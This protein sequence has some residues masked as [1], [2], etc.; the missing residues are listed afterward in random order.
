MGV[1][2]LRSLEGMSC[3]WVLEPGPRSPPFSKWTIIQAMSGQVKD[4]LEQG[5]ALLKAAGAREVYVFGSVAAACGLIWRG[6]AEK[7]RS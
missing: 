3:L 2:G 1:R 6:G 5:A 7:K 4:F